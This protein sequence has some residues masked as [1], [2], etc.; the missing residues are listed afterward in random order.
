MR[1]GIK[2]K[3][4]AGVAIIVGLAVTAVSVIHLTTLARVHL[5]ESRSRGELLAQTVFHRAYDVVS[6]QRDP[7]AALRADRGLRSILEASIYSRNVTYAA[8]VDA[9]GIA[10]VHSDPEA[11][12]QSMPALEDLDSLLKRDRISQLRTIYAG[13]GRTL[14]FREPLMLGTRRFGSI[15]VGVSTLLIRRDLDQALRPA[16]A[17]A[18]LALGV[19]IFVALVFAQLILRPIHVIRSGLSR[20]GS[21]EPD[22]RLDLPQR[23]EFGDLGLSFNAMSAQLS[24]ERTQLAGQKASL[25]TVVEK[26]EDAVAVVNPDGEILFANPAMRGLL[27][28]D[29]VGRRLDA[30]LAANHAIR[31]LTEQALSTGR[32]CGPDAVSLVPLGGATGE[33]ASDSREYLTMAHAIRGRDDRLVGAMVVARDLEYLGQVQSTINYSRKLTALGRLSSGIAHEVR[34]PLNAMTIHLELLKQKLARASAPTLGP[35]AVGLSVGETANAVYGGT[36]TVGRTEGVGS[37]LSGALQHVAIIGGEI[38]RLDEVV[39]GLLKFTRPEDLRL[40][41]LQPRTLIDEMLG[42][43]APETDKA[44]VRVVVDEGRSVPDINGD[45][46]LLQQAFFNLALN[47][48]Q[49]M[50]QGGTLRIAFAS[51]PGRRVSVTFE[52]TGVGIQPL[53]LGKIFDLYFTTKEAGTGIGL[54]MVFRIV[55]MHGGD[56]EVQ[57]TP[58][59][60][61]TFR[62][63]LPQA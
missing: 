34:N 11:E 32:P 14:E 41:P 49:A 26:L 7:H 17:T 47:A 61:T 24:A 31:R 29:A 54:S 55:Q 51:A 48:C 28:A 39:Q 5:E 16:L 36:A 27:G 45:A 62:L 63:L 12:G 19:A 52:D 23:D 30:L 3:Q 57:S 1:L 21:G 8:I 9:G 60:G 53:N 44:G 33:G 6:G 59:A 37:A 25:E 4:V 13:A 18:L 35:G 20:L 15:R 22:V 40:Q 10:I 46:S 2:A 58:G 43:L 42:V 50:P 56:I 38:R